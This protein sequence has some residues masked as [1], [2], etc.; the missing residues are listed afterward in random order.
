MK[1]NDIPLG[2]LID[3]INEVRESRRILAAQDK[4]LEA[5]YKDLEEKIKARLDA[6]GMDKA[7]GKKAT[8]SLTTVTVATIKD[9]DAVCKWVKKTGH[10]QLFQ[11]RISDP[12]YREILELKKAGVPGLDA[13]D[14]INL[15]LRA[16]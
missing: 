2:A 14:K 8:A 9:W 16:L 12:A 1:S 3:S 10:F 13:F 15:N 11:R 5:T 4:E 7:T 6:E